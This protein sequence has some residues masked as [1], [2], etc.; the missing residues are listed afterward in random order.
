MTSDE[1]DLVLARIAHEALH[2][3]TLETRNR[4]ALDFHT[5]AVWRVREALC[6]AF[7]AGAAEGQ[8]TTTQTTEVK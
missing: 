1:R 6:R 8:N 4:D 7:T 3:E 2:M 5:L